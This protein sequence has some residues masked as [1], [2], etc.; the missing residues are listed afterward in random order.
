M[1]STLP[2]AI[3]EAPLAKRNT[4]KKF[5]GAVEPSDKDSGYYRKLGDG[6]RVLG[7]SVLVDLCIL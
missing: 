4:I 5:R 1:H 2:P 6:G 7:Y 3:S